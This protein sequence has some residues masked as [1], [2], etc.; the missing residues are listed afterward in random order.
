MFRFLKAL[1]QSP[2]G[3]LHMP[4]LDV[5]NNDAFSTRSLTAAILKAPYKPGRLGELGL[6]SESGIITTTA[7][8]E[9]QEGQLSLIQTSPR[10]APGS[11]L[12]NTK[13]NM[14]AFNIPHLQRDS[15]I[16]AD[17]VQGVRA[18]AT[19]NELQ[20]VQDL[21]NLRL[22][23]LRAMHEVTLEHLRMGALK[24]VILDADG[25][26]VIYNL[27]TEF[28]VAQQVIDFDFG[29]SN[30]EVRQQCVAVLRAIE[31]ELG[32]ST[33]TGARA[34]CSASFFDQLIDHPLVKESFKATT[35]ANV[36]RI[37]LRR[38]FPF[39]GIMFEE[40]RGSVNGVDFI[41]DD[42]AF[43]FPEGAQTVRG[44]LFQTWF[45][46]ADFE[47]TVNTIGLP[48][49]AKQAPDPDGLNRK[50]LI[51]TQSNP[52]PI[53]LRPRAVIKLTMTT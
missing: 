2:D 42:E 33:Y 3:M 11:T 39:G 4:T 20:T 1:S 41:P 23:T 43:V 12:G 46:P 38:G 24:G 27:F 52:L 9:E 17:Q 8:V 10:G 49:Y 28:D 26:S 48:L 32:G 37:D 51:H 7:Q 22:S 16:L 50:R 21:V 19:E 18:F 14:R 36:L 44:P 53:C 15:E 25:S 40:Y 13:R 31:S 6:F 45:A 5:F 29:D 34:F 35:D 30:F 47:E